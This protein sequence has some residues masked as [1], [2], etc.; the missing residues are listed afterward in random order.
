MRVVRGLKRA[1]P[2]VQFI[3]TTHEPLCLRGLEDGEIAVLRR[4]SSHRS[5]LIDDLPSVRGLLVDQI[6][7]SAHFG[8]GSTVDPE[9]AEKFDRYYALLAKTPLN[10]AERVE[11]AWLRDELDRIRLIGNTPSE[12]ILLHVIDER[13]ARANA[14]GAPLDP[15]NLPDGLKEELLSVLELASAKGSSKKASG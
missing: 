11:L 5:A 6:L 2:R 3:A 4:N 13:V 9:T 15:S 8:L 1:F 12:Q 10:G 14:V 7:S